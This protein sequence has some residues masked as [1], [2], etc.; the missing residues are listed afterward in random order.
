[1]KLTVFLLTVACLQVH[2]SGLA[3]R[4]T[5]SVKGRPL[6]SVFQDIKNQTG[7][8]FWYNMD[9]LRYARNVTLKANNEDLTQVLAELFKDQPLS[10]EIIDRTIA[11]KLKDSS[12]TMA[13]PPPGITVSGRVTDEKGNP[14][15]GV[16]IQVRAHGATRGAQGGDAAQATQAASGAAQDAGGPARG[17]QTDANGRFSLEN[18]RENAVLIFSYVGYQ[19]QEVHVN[20]RTTIDITLRPVPQAIGDLVVVG[21]GK[22]SRQNLTSAISTLKPDDLNQGAITDVGQLLQG[23]APGLNITASGDPN[24]PAAV[25]LRGASTINSPGGPFYVIDG[26][27][28]ADISTVAPDDIASVDIL[29]DAAATAIY[30]NRASNGVIMITTKRGRKGQTQVS[31]NGYVGLEEVSRSLKVMNASQLRAFVKKNG[32]G[33]SAADDQGANT[34]WQKAIE[35]PSAVSTN[36]NLSFSGGGDHGSYSASLNY[37]QKEGIIRNTDLTRIIGRLNI[38]QYAFND[39]VKFSLGV[40]NSNSNGDE[41]PYLGVILLQA[42]KYLP[43]SPVKNPDGSYFEDLTTGNQNPVAMM[44]NSTMNDKNNNLIGSLNTDVKLPWGLSYD[45]NLSYQSYSNLHG[46]Y[47]DSYFTSH[48]NDMYNNPNPGP[49]SRTQ[50]SFGPNGQAYRSSY[51]STA[52]VME[53]YFTWD[54]H[55][56]AHALNAVLGYSWQDNINNDGFQV[57]SFNYPVDNIGYNNFALSAPYASPTYP[58]ISLGPDGLYQETKLIADFARVNY[59]FQ[60][61][62]LLQGSIRRDGSSVFGANH[63]FGYF[64]SVGLGWRLTKEK[65]FHIPVLDDLK[66]RGSYGVTG[67]A[68][69]FNAYTAQ[70]FSGSLGTYYYNG[71]QVNAYGPTQAANPYLQWE[72]TATG[73]VGL[74]A[75]AF[76]GRIAASVDL[77]N[78]KTTEMI[79]PYSVNPVLVPS[80][81]IVANGGGMSNKGIEVTLTAGVIRKTDFTWTTALNLTHN[82]NKITSL[83]NP[84]F[85][86]VDSIPEAQPS[87]GGESGVFIQVLKAGKALGTYYSLQYAGKNASGVTQFYDHNGNPTVSPVAGTDYHYLGNAQPKLLL[88]WTNTFRYKRWDLRVFMR[89]VFGD[90]L[91]DAT[92]ADLFRPA[93]AGTANILVDAGNES[94]ADGNVFRYSSRFVENGAYLRLDNATLD[95]NVKGIDPYVKSI[96]LYVTVNNL[97]VLTGYKGIDPEINQ[98][99]IAPGVDYNDF[100][101]KTRTFLFGANVNF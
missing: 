51:T 61:K 41:V 15:A 98:G 12:V 87:G 11:V 33:F 13:E 28:G 26:V 96:R 49:A 54:R 73:E 5:L 97:F 42:A 37:A 77:Y 18:I 63:Q 89:G 68:F 99:G 30:G 22:A 34:D 6:E 65:W 78:K 95:Y 55:F 2:A 80:G 9:V 94:S 56:G 10:Y 92:R 52:K 44:N 14:L 38:D 19:E 71:N 75:A 76:K 82:V 21:Y 47:Y 69:G 3:Q 24:V 8:V 4:V 84:L 20:G 60:D 48:Y 85:P 88:G 27:P 39:R 36:H 100:Y 35:R 31:Y 70:F 7:Y 91:F 29:K 58:H 66:L 32:L 50:Q 93:T 72:Q 59:S 86:G 79:F 1:M 53:M 23:R 64:P 83:N 40:V 16:S 17:A 90:K 43:V 81:S 67:N 46:E 62:Y 74:D 45:I 25:I 57:T 101:P